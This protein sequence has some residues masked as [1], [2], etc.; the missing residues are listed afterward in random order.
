M[1]P[2]RE[3]MDGAAVEDIQERLGRL[4]YEIDADEREKGSFGKST[5]TAV[6]KFR[7]DH[8]L[9]L[10]SEVD[11][12]TWAALVD[13]GYELGDRT[14]YLRLPNQHGRDVHTL[15]ERL[16]VLG[17]SC[18]KPDGC[19]GVHT[20]AAVKQFQENVGVLADGMAF[21]DTF[22]AIERLHHVWGGKP[23]AGPH[24]QG[25]MGF[26]RAASVL[27]ETSMA[28]AAT[29]PISRNVAARIWNLAQATNDK[30]DVH[31]L[32]NLD[33]DAEQDRLVFLLGVGGPAVGSKMANVEV[34][35]PDTL[36]LRIRTACESSR[37]DNPVVR[38]ELP[39]G[40]SYDGTF[41]SSDAQTLA[42]LLLDAI[43]TAFTPDAR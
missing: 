26:A 25:G 9:S 10:G 38:L 21:Q 13:E 23:A 6:A 1:D 14:L 19:Y 39:V 2:I 22:D 4:G 28:L 34:D 42:V 16:N 29:D 3:G 31:L 27:E 5:A 24:P 30:A 43:C 40:H 37:A 7:L 12:A 20:E 32:E 35:D 8:D 11:S 36:P 15:Q 33:A 18:G 41:S 17:F